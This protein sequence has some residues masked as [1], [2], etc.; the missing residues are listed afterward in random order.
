MFL[1]LE[2]LLVL[3]FYIRFGRKWINFCQP[4]GTL[5]V[6]KGNPS[7]F[8]DHRGKETGATCILVLFLRHET[9]TMFFLALSN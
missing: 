9:T 8:C 1:L 5:L 6:F 3:E 2:T 4:K 7:F